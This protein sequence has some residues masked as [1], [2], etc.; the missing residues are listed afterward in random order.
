MKYLQDIRACHQ[1]PR[2]LEEL[3]QA[4]RREDET[5]A[6]TSALLACHEASPDNVLYAA[7]YYR[8]GQ[9]QE[10]RVAGRSVNWKLAVPLSIVMGLI[11]WILS[12]PSLEFDDHT[13]YFF[14]IWAL[15]GGC[16]AIAFLTFTSGE[17]RD[18]SLLTAAGLVVAGVYVTLFTL[19]S[20]HTYYRDLMLFHLPLLAW[21]GVGLSVLG[22]ASE[23]G[24]RFAFLAK[25]FEV[26]V[27]GGVYLIAGGIFAG[28]TLGMFEALGVTLQE[29]VMRLLLA[30]G[31]GLIP[32][33]TVASVYDPLVR[34]AVQ[35]F[36]QGVGK[37]ISTLMR[38]LLPL[39]LLVLII[40]LL[41][42]PFNFMEPFRKREVLIVYNGMLFA[43]MGLLVGVT[44]VREGKLSQKHQAT[45]RH[46]IL[47]VAFLTVLVSLYALSAIISRTLDD[48]LTVNRLAV[49]GWN[50]INTGILCLLI[51]KQLKDGPAAW[52]RSLQSTFSVGAIGYVVWTIFLILAIPLL[53]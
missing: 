8:L 32:V 29:T 45:L 31:L 30:G 33:L 53:F 26:F 18:R 25:S 12:D 23:P 24:E 20:G 35:R 22:I 37:L 49:I 21:M 4:A 1:D 36:E 51:Y 27:T 34:P 43:I 44:P 28:V 13:P 14:L 16:F 40:Y 5:E 50:S 6:F 46:G 2:R 52:I 47:A 9:T 17:H 42:I 3:Y 39:T 48:R 19:P 15:I 41:I 38:L 10:D 7:W 11:Y